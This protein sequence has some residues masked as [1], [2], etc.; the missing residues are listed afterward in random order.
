MKSLTP[1]LALLIAF[2]L[3]LT[4]ALQVTAAGAHP[5][6]SPR[7]TCE[8]HDEDEDDDDD[9][10]DEDEDEDDENEDEEWGEVDVDVIRDFYEKHSP[11]IVKEWER[12]EDE[13]PEKAD[14]LADDLIRR[15]YE[16]Q[17]EFEHRPEMALE[18]L[19]Y[20]QGEYHAQKMGDAIH[21]MIRRA[22]RSPSKRIDAEIKKQQ[23]ALQSHL[24]TLFD[25]RLKLEKAELADMQSDMKQLQNDIKRRE[26]NREKIIQK[27]LSRLSGKPDDL[28][29]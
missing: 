5:T 20:D 19:H 12:L 7:P 16:F 10:H 21:D 26:G 17:E 1:L 23:A 14:R 3:T 9:E 25:L 27:Y 15:Y 18:R 11:G 24:S 8:G 13:D 4:N 28:D 29:W 22:K 2:L 6:F